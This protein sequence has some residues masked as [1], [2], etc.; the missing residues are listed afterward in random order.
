MEEVEV[1]RGKLEEKAAA[2]KEVKENNIEVSAS[3]KEMTAQCKSVS[4]EKLYLEIENKE[5]KERLE[6][7]SAKVKNHEKITFHAS[8]EECCDK[9]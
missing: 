9:N 7:L 5:L 8:K 4:K 6:E 3:L 2:L 1:L